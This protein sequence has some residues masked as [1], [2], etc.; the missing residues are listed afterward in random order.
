MEAKKCKTAVLQGT[1]K[2]VREHRKITAGIHTAMILR[3]IIIQETKITIVAK[4]VQVW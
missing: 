1:D 3:H 4:S 2:A